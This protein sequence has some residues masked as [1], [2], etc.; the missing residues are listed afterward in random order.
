MFQKN[1]INYDENESVVYMKNMLQAYTKVIK[2]FAYD[3]TPKVILTLYFQDI[4]EDLEKHMTT[5]LT[6]KEN[7]TFFNAVNLAKI[8]EAQNAENEIEKI[9]QAL[10]L[11]DNI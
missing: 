1:S 2:D 3:Y 7:Q 6:N 4:L 9:F 5:Q 11:L 10:S 8:D